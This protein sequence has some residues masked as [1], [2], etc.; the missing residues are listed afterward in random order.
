MQTYRLAH[1]CLSDVV[2]VSDSCAC[3]RSTLL[4]TVASPSASFGSSFTLHLPFF[5]TTSATWRNAV[6]NHL[7]LSLEPYLEN[8][9]SVALYQREGALCPMTRFSSFEFRESTKD[10]PL[11]ASI[12]QVRCCRFRHSALLDIENLPARLRCSLSAPPS[13][14]IRPNNILQPAPDAFISLNEDGF[15]RRGVFH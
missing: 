14:K 1:T 10:F 9:R 12:K 5:C 13:C 15:R 2:R 3:V 11:T 6:S 4:A 7:V 8:P